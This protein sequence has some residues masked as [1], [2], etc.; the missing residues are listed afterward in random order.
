[1]SRIG[2]KLIPMIE[3][4][5]VVVNGN[6]VDIKG[7]KGDDHI[8][9]AAPLINVVVEEGHVKVTRSNDEKHTKQ[10]HGTTR[11]L[12]ANAIEGC[13]HEFTKTLDIVGIGYKA[14][15]KGKD[16]VLHVGH[17][18]TTVVTPLPE[19][20]IQVVDQKIK[21]V[22]STIIVSGPDKFAVGQTAALIRDAR[23]P[24]PY[25]GKGIHYRGEHL[26]H[27][28]GKRAA[29]GSGPAKK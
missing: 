5:T 14:E 27:K 4:V 24:E 13:H 11:A 17:T 2:N 21:D 20:T 3:G 18:K 9:F 23:R 16:V 8:K 25:L 29:A 28:E 10:L 26:V 15:M 22:T 12:I 6:V 7:P 1:M 19:V